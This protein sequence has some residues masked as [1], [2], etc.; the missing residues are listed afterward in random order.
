LLKV[1]VIGYH[2]PPSYEVGA[3]RVARLCRYLPEFGISP[4]VLTV[5]TRFIDVCD[6]SFAVPAGVDV[7]RTT[8]ITCPLD[9]YHQWKMN[10]GP[11]R[12]SVEAPAMA[13]EESSE[14]LN[15]WIKRQMISFW[16]IPDRFCGWYWP[17]VRAAEMLLRQQPI[18]LIISSGPPWTS[19]L[20]A[21]H[22]RKKFGV[23][24]I[25]DFR[26][27]WVTN[28]WRDVPPW[29]DMLDSRLEASCIRW[30]DLILCASNR[31]RSQFINRYRNVSGSRLVTLTNGFDGA[32]P[33]LPKMGLRSSRVVCLHLGDLYGRRRIDTFCRAMVNLIDAGRLDPGAVRVRFVG[34]CDDSILASAHEIAPHLIQNGC[35]EFRPRLNWSEGQQLLF[36]ANFLLIFQGDHPAVPA[37]FYEYLQT[38]KPIFAIVKEGELSEILENTGS[39]V[40][41][42]PENPQDIASNFMKM[43]ELPVRTQED[44]TRLTELYHFRS[45]AERLAG[46]VHQLARKPTSLGEEQNAS[47]SS[48]PVESRNAVGS[49]NAQ[50][51]RDFG[52]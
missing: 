13:S 39:G 12:R 24:W 33:Y 51:T 49:Q 7:I 19:H 45:L 1:L 9:W 34:P 52:A 35:I 16:R 22:L 44:M 25:A 2:F 43:L 41:A 3:K 5:E 11:A 23:P 14:T 26:D 47:I 50:A 17:A 20:I 36:D 29:R 37:K 6:E 42:N 30:A 28:K 4:I 15:Q 40:W 10:Q 31:I 32:L 27:E 38:G 46:L 18:S 21:R 8:R 48:V